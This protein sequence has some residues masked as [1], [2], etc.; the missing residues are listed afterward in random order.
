ME[1][2]CAMCIYD[3]SVRVISDAITIIH[4][5]AVCGQHLD[6]AT[7]NNFYDIM[8]ILNAAHAEEPAE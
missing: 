8:R 1:L 7:Q 4:G 5:V 3:D 6:R 2:S